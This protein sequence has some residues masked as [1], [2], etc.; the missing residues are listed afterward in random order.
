LAL[1]DAA[2]NL[3]L[4]ALA[5]VNPTL[6]A[7]YAS[8]HTA[9]PGSTGTNEVSG[10][11]PPYARRAITWNTATSGDLDDNTIPAFDVPASTTITHFGL[12]S[13]STAG[14][15]LGGGTLDATQIFST[16]GTY[17]LTDLD[18]TL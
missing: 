1:T 18:V 16:Q 2:K 10:G 9:D 3:M 17:T 14:T 7:A 15:F 11:S 12:W 4:N 13:A 8:L 6:S 5:G